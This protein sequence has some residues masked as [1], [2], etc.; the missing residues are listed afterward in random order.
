M[1][2]SGDKQSDFECF[3]REQVAGRDDESDIGLDLVV[4][5]D[6]LLAKCPQVRTVVRALLKTTVILNCLLLLGPA[7]E[8]KQ[9]T[10]KCLCNNC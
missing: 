6:H 4:N 8:K 1:G 7:S 2:D 9:D 5:N 3:T 10:E